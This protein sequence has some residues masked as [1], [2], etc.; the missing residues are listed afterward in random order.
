M[1]KNT[2][3]PWVQDILE[4]FQKNKRDLPWRKD[5][6]PYKVWI[7]E[8]MLQQTRVN[9][10]IPYYNRFLEHYSTVESLAESSLEDLYRLWEGLGYYSRAKNMHLTAKMILQKYYGVFPNTYKELVQLPGIGDYTASAIM[11]LA[12]NRSYPAVDGNVL[13]FISRLKNDA[14][15]IKSPAFVKNVRLYLQ[16]LVPAGQA[17]NFTE[18]LME[19]GSLL[20]V[21]K[22]PICDICP[23]SSNCSA[24]IDGNQNN[25]P[26]KKEKSKSPVLD[27]LVAVIEQQDNILIAKRQETGL[28]ADLY[29]FPVFPLTSKKDFVKSLK[30]FLHTRG[31]FTSYSVE[32]QGKVKHEYSHQIWNS[33][34]YCIKLLQDD[35]PVHGL[36]E[37][38]SEYV[39]GQDNSGK[40][41]KKKEF[42]WVKKQETKNYPISRFFRKVEELLR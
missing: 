1:K 2:S 25:L 19:F 29:E 23:I 40:K 35:I 33:K 28:L 3:E 31:I 26:V 22:Q 39:T 6:S 14:S 32:Y 5:R 13:R 42:F 36:R 27:I 30:L 20:C 37:A 24:Y 18:A 17:R 10:V 8:I 21:P 4:W 12:Y 11:S 15:D 7:S 38:S 9:A 16:E 34:V 41:E